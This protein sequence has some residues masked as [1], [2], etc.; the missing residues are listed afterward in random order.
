MRWW[1]LVCLA[2][3][4]PSCGADTASQDGTD[5]GDSGETGQ[6]PECSDVEEYGGWEEVASLPSPLSELELVLGPNGPIVLGTAGCAE[7]E[8]PG[9]LAFELAEGEAQWR[10]LPAMPQV[11][12]EPVA[13]VLSDGAVL[14]ASGRDGETPLLRMSRAQGWEILDAL[15]R[16]DGVDVMGATVDDV[17]LAAKESAGLGTTWYRSGDRGVSWTPLEEGP[18]VVLPETVPPGALGPLGGGLLVSG[19]G[20]AHRYDT[21]SNTW[22]R[23]ELGPGGVVSA[24]VRFNPGTLFAMMAVECCY[25]GVGAIPNRPFGILWSVEAAE[26]DYGQEFGHPCPVPSNASVENWETEVYGSGAGR[27]FVKL[28]HRGLVFEEDAGFLSLP[29]P[30]IVFGRENAIALPDGTFLVVEHCGDE[31][32]RW[33]PDAA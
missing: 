18:N 13:T 27:A 17:L 7:Q 4:L 5:G 30:P 14:V 21:A 31:V 20:G 24:A 6:E 28:N 22:S 29:E 3:A 1:R 11:L 25:G 19:I 23:V 32:W 33:K 15:P 26:D 12:R 2:A 10:A 16:E 9:G 8:L